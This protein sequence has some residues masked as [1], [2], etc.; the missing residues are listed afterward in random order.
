LFY[1]H[2]RMADGHLNK[3]KTCTKLDVAKVAPEVRAEYERRR[4]VKPERKAK[5]LIYVRRMRERSP[6]KY[7]ARNAV[8]NALRDGRLTKTPCVNC[9]SSD[10]VQAHHYDYRKH[11][12]VKWLCFKCHR[13]DEHGSSL[14][15]TEFHTP[16][17]RVFK[18]KATP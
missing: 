5:R 1:K 2:P 14:G 13:K 18:K 9:G 17:P 11:L 4:A 7:K 3:C 6:G 15:I 8:A 10:R 12:D 16:V